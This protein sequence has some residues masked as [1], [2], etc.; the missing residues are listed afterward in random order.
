MEG[1]RHHKLIY[2]RK[3]DAPTSYYL[4]DGELNIFPAR[5]CFTKS[6][7][8]NVCGGRKSPVGQFKATFKK[9]ESSIYCNDKRTLHSNIYPV[10]NHTSAIFGTGDVRNTDD[11]LIF[12]DLTAGKW[13]II[14][15]H[16]FPGC[17][18][19]VSQILHSYFK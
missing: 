2:K 6:Q 18:F 1:N 15:I 12:E 9:T 11:L 14:V 5:V 19:S 16:I 3:A 17:K 13:D 10:Q 4:Q 8:A 7:F